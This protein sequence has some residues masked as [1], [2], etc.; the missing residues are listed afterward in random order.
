MLTLAVDPGSVQ[1]GYV[2]YQR[3]QVSEHLSEDK[4]LSSGILL[5]SQLLYFYCDVLIIEKPEAR[6]APLGKALL[7]TIYFS[8][9]NTTFFT[10]I[11]HSRH[12]HI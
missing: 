11:Q 4:I 1:S 12:H 7:E 10:Q 9:V 8:G 2:H 3:L 6:Q 5:N